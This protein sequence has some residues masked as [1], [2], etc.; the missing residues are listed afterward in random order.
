MISNPANNTKLAGE[1]KLTPAE[2]PLSA[3]GMI[4]QLGEMTIRQLDIVPQ[5]VDMTN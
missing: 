2:I 3:A 5:S 1:M 4:K